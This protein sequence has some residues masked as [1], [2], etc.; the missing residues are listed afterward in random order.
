[1]V[2]GYLIP[3]CKEVTL[4]DDLGL[5]T[6]DC[7]DIVTSR[8]DKLRKG[9]EKVEVV[10][11]SE[12]PKIRHIR[13][14]LP[15]CYTISSQ[16][17]ELTVV[18]PIIHHCHCSTELAIPDRDQVLCDTNS[19]TSVDNCNPCVIHGWCDCVYWYIRATDGGRAA[20]I[21]RFMTTDMEIWLRLCRIYDVHDTESALSDRSRGIICKQQRSEVAALSRTTS[22]PRQ[23]RAVHHKGL[24]SPLKLLMTITICF[25]LA[26]LD[27]ALDLHLS[28]PF[29]AFKR[30]NNVKY[31][32]D[33]THSAR[34]LVGAR[35][36]SNLEK[37]TFM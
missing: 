15:I 10:T 35:P 26:D 9:F 11:V 37:F 33:L 30:T 3:K 5:M 13:T 31:S 16:K 25:A 18:P 1:M 32:D 27:P 36:C 14:L 22:V 21:R 4:K 2:K 12:E 24:L 34:S 28:F 6:L 29:S 8:A 17:V 7:L 23:D 20:T 19:R